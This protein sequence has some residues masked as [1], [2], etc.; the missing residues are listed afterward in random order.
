VTERQAEIVAKR[1]TADNFTVLFWS[2]GAITNGMQFYPKG[3]RKI[4]VEAMWAVAGEVEAFDWS[5]LPT[6]MRAA[7]R[8]YR[9]DGKVTPATLRNETVEDLESA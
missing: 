4:P 2:D 1:K 5:E 9:R 3:I 8:I 6:L 7:R